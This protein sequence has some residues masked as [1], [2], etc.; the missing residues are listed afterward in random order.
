MRNDESPN[1]DPWTRIMELIRIQA[2]IRPWSGYRLSPASPTT[3]AGRSLLNIRQVFT[4]S[5][6]NDIP[7]TTY[8]ARNALSATINNTLLNK[9]HYFQ[10][11]PIIFTTFP[12]IITDTVCRY[13]SKFYHLNF[14]R[15]EVTQFWI[16]Q[17]F[18]QLRTHIWLHP[19]LSGL[20]LLL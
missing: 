8:C 19:G 4:N 17:H 18:C 13:C 3:A 12:E 9:H 11:S 16:W 20:L 6:I 7:R 10:N 15:S 1:T 5:L 2:R 14:G